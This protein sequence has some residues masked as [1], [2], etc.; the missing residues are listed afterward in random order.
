MVDGSWQIEKIEIQIPGLKQE[1]TFLQ[2][3]DA[4]IC[5]AR[6]GDSM[7][8]K[9]KAEKHTLAWTQK[10]IA[11]R[12]AFADALS[13]AA[14]IKADGLF[15]TGDCMDYYSESNIACMQF[16]LKYAEMEKLYVPG[17][18]EWSDWKKEKGV[19]AG[20]GEMMQG[21]PAC[22][23]RDYGEFL[24]VGMD[25][26]ALTLSDAQL[27]FL[28]AQ[29]ERKLPILLLVHVPL[30]TEAISPS[31]MK[32][33]GTT[34]MIGTEEDSANAH[35]FCR[36]VRDPGSPVLAIFAGHIHFAH[37]GEFAPGKMQYAAAPCLEKFLR[38]IHVAG[39]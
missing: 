26:S 25:D 34:F 24:V 15:M 28:K 32:R 19:P 31:I 39:E 29:M 35:A 2:I 7:A 27:D 21:N 37:T 38:V 33:W 9:E 10:E 13:Y 17:N 20:Y 18:H 22:W 30:C 36:L 23:V 16:S 6:R 3:S 12:D 4:H 14:E 1:Y 8:A 5:H 11:P